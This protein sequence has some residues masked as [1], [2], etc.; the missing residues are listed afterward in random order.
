MTRSRPWTLAAAAVLAAVA[1]LGPDW[2]GPG[3]AQAET[4]PAQPDPTAPVVVEL[5]TSQG[6]NSCPPADALLGELAQNP[7]IIALSMHVDYWDYIGW[8][9]PYASQE[10]TKRQHR[11]AQRLGLRYVY[12]P[13]MVIDGQADVVGVRRDEVLQTI[14]QA[15]AQRKALEVRF[16]QADGGK[17]V[18][19]AGHAPDGGAVVWLAVYDGSHETDV[20]RGE[21]A[22]RKLRNHNVVRELSRIAL[23]HGERLEIPFD[24]AAA[25]AQGRDGCA[26]IVQQT[27][28]GPVLGAAAMP[29]EALRQ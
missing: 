7:G 24:M 20:A 15:A 19:P 14:E 13:Q 27:G 8:K 28:G 4:G 2:S 10:A 22:G 1:M 5:F 29:L 23:W 18:I 25:A 17:I 9:D 21:N 6:C 16:E 11:Y 3:T 12:T 26:V